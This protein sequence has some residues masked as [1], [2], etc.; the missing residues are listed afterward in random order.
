MTGKPRDLVHQRQ[1]WFYNQRAYPLSHI[2]AGARLKALYQLDG[3]MR[4]Q[5]ERVYNSD[6]ARP[7]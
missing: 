1:E 6:A 5:A 7:A 3:M 4:T 2:P